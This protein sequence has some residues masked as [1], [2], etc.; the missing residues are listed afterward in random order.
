MHNCT[1]PY[2]LGEQEFHLVLRADDF[3]SARTLRSEMSCICYKNLAMGIYFIQ[4]PDEY[5]IEVLPRVNKFSS[6]KKEGQR[7]R[8]SPLFHITRFL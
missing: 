6:Y 1:N 5:W 2:D 3:E 4:D 7:A 8:R